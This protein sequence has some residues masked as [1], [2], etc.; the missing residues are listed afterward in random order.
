MDSETE[1][2]LVHK[3]EMQEMDFLKG[4]GIEPNFADVSRH[5]EEVLDPFLEQ[6]DLQDEINS[7]TYDNEELEGQ[8]SDL[9]CKLSSLGC[10]AK[11]LRKE[12]DRLDFEGKGEIE[13][14]LGDIE[15]ELE[16]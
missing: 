11:S 13:A 14:I 10:L 3:A 7:L 4:L 1:G 6:E 16:L 15:D 12:L 2:K 8:V 5:M 9:E